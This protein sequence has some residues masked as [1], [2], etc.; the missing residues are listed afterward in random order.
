MNRLWWIIWIVLFMCQ[1]PNFRWLSLVFIG[2]CDCV[3]IEVGQRRKKCQHCC[4][5]WDFEFLTGGC[6]S[7][8]GG[9]NWPLSKGFSYGS[10]TGI[11]AYFWVVANSFSS[12]RTLSLKKTRLYFD[13]KR[14]IISTYAQLSNLCWMPNSVSKGFETAWKRAHQ[15]NSNDTPQPIGECQ[16][17]FHL[18]RIRINRD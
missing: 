10:W 18:L 12:C 2:D 16:V 4:Q 3:C 9:D 15:D 8:S 17:S 1:G 6:L 13:D 14:M 5:K 7:S 11:P